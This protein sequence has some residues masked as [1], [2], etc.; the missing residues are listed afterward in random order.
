VCARARALDLPLARLSQS[1][2]MLPVLS[3]VVCVTECIVK[4]F[5]SPELHRHIRVEN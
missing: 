3:A 2:F 4:G 1:F 5:C